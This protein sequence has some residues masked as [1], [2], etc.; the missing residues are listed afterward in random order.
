MKL[1]ETSEMESGTRAVTEYVSLLEMPH[2]AVKDLPIAMVDTPG[3][4]DTEGL[5]QDAK[6]VFAIQKYLN[7]HLGPGKVPNLILLLI[8]STENRLLGS[9]SRFKKQVACLKQLKVTDHRKSNIV[10]VVTHAC[11][12]ITAQATDDWEAKF[13]QKI[14]TALSRYGGIEGTP[15][16]FIENN[17]KKYGLNFDESTG[18]SCLPNGKIQPRYIF[19]QMLSTLKDAGDDLGYL[20]V[21]QAYKKGESPREASPSNIIAASTPGTPLSR[22]EQEI[23]ETLRE[24]GE[25]PELLLV[26][27]REAE[28]L[29]MENVC[30]LP[31]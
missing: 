18:A 20:A 14:S 3:M 19:D 24:H 30:V 8:R 28:K 26:L 27:R 21:K 10:V 16:V 9:E 31:Y 2:L 1:A 13:T 29:R 4:C 6:N 11:M 25:E 22:E 17:H 7:M 12:Q 5:D 15:V 23:R